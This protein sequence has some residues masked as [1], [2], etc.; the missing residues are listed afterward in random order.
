MKHSGHIWIVV[1]FITLAV[2]SGSVRAWDWIGFY[3]LDAEAIV[4]FYGTD[5]RSENG[6][7]FQDIE[8]RAGVHLTQKGYILDPGIAQFLLDIEPV[9]I[10]GRIESNTAKDDRNGNFL[11]YLVQLN[12]L[13]GTPGPFSFDLSA[14]RSSNLNTLAL[15]SRFENVIEL[16]SASGQWRNSAFPMQF[17]YSERSLKQEFT[18]SGSSIISERDELLKT[19]TI[20]GRSSKMNLL[21]ERQ[22]MDDR[23]VTRN[24]DYD[25]D[26]A[27]FNHKFL[28]GRDS[29]LRSRLYYLNRTGFNFN[30]RLTIVET[31]DI[32]HTDTIFSRSIYSFNSVAQTFETN[33]HTLESTLTHQLYSN[34][35]TSVRV[36]GSS[37]TSNNLDQTRWRTELEGQYQKQNLFLGAN[38]YI[39]L[40]V[41]YQETDRNSSFGLAEVIDEAHVV[42]LG[43]MIILNRRFI[44]SATILVTSADG[45]LV[46]TE[47]TDYIVFDVTDDLTQLQ[48]VPGGRISTGDTIL[49]SYKLQVLP[50]QEFSTTFTRIRLGFNLGW[51]NF[52]HYSRISDDRLLSG[53]GES[54]L[55]D[56]RD[57]AT[58]LEFRWRMADIDSV[59][60]AE[61][62]YNK[63]INFESTTFTFRQF[64]SWDGFGDTLWNLNMVESFGETNLISTDLYTLELSANWQPVM[65]LRIRPT[66]GAWKRL[67]KGESISGGQRD[68][69]FITAGISMRWQYRKVSLDLAYHY[70]RRTTNARLTNENI[71]LFNLRRRF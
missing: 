43:G 69:T 12:L 62:R 67:D 60:G 16:N 59:V 3:P 17:I 33:E 11:S 63:T 32:Q 51:M 13:R 61:R 58:N 49:V 24:R 7:F 70:N 20:K 71:L 53:A 26:R 22:S 56:Y 42:T 14:M 1:T 29:Q 64:F 54:F 10:G 46:F 34:L 27:S 37:L 25:L 36:F 47:G 66:L 44:V 6:E 31:A 2:I 55:N 38:A 57:I 65:N 8:W 15:G 4:R 5:R 41:S 45:A 9:Y 50:S 30:K 19:F 28:W 68:D 21:L 40:A 39:G 52:S 18:S 23:V 48:V 35:T